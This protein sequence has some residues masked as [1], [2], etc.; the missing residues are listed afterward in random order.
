MYAISRVYEEEPVVVQ[1]RVPNNALLQPVP[2]T[3]Q[4]TP[5]PPSPH[6]QLRPVPPAPRRAPQM[7]VQDQRKHQLG[8][9]CDAC[10]PTFPMLRPQQAVQSPFS[11]TRTQHHGFVYEP[12]Q[13]PHPRA[14]TEQDLRTLL[15]PTILQ[16]LR[17]SIEAHPLIWLGVSYVLNL[18]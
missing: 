17:A 4:R 16:R 6:V 15:V 2:P 8:C 3:L 7:S 9:A 12:V 13:A 14:G 18:F 11:P 5:L 1:R 10:Q